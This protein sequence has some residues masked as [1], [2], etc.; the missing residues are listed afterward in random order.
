M[1]VEHPTLGRYRIAYVSKP[2][3]IIEQGYFLRSKGKER[4]FSRTEDAQ[5]SRELSDVLASQHPPASK[6]SLY[7]GNEAVLDV[8]NRK[9][10]TYHPSDDIS[11][12][13]FASNVI[14]STNHVTEDLLNER[15]FMMIDSPLRTRKA[16]DMLGVHTI[17]D[18]IKIT[19]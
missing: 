18:L 2:D 16:F 17:A 10:I 5:P 19:T 11:L 14:H 3:E 1:N 13:D 12:E 6:V 15:V 8:A 7:Q 9:I 4:L